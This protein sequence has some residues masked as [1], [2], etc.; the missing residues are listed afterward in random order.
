MERV[1]FE[2]LVLLIYNK[3]QKNNSK[4]TLSI[5]Y[6]LFFFVGCVWCLGVCLVVLV[7]FLLFFFLFFFLQ[8]CSSFLFLLFL[9]SLSFLFSC[10]VLLIACSCRRRRGR[11]RRL[12]RP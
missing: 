3:Q 2:L 5:P 10:V 11:C 1:T 7:V 8:L 6:C 9:L 4:V 12:R